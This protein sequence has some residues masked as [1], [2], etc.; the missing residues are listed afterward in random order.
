MAAAGGPCPR[1]QCALPLPGAC[2]PPANERTLA[3]RP[4]SRCAWRRPPA[5]RP[6]PPPPA[7]NR[8][9][10]QWGLG[11]P[12][13]VGREGWGAVSVSVAQGKD[14]RWS[15]TDRCEQ[16][17]RLP[18]LQTSKNLSA[19]GPR[20]RARPPR[21]RPCAAGPAWVGSLAR[22][23]CEC[24]EGAGVRE[25]ARLWRQHGEAE[26]GA[27]SGRERHAPPLSV[28]LWLA[29]S[30]SPSPTPAFNEELQ[31]VARLQQRAHVGCRG[32]GGESRGVVGEGGGYLARLPTWPREC[33]D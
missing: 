2:K 32:R 23:G 9:S 14:G 12:A 4:G 22:R 24:V 10:W 33:P 6:R 11:R 5:A 26:R 17:P 19:P 13:A 28:P 18:A 25:A 7:A 20:R 29:A 27:A 16:H 30:D 3:S 15:H 21:R 8:S 31:R 1:T